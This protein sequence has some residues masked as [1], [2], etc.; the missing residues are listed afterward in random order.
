MKRIGII[1]G[2][3]WKSTLH[4]YEQL[5]QRVNEEAGGLTSADMVLRSVNF[6]EFY[7]LMK[8]GKWDVIEQK[9]YDEVRHL[10][11]YEKC[12]YV[13]IATNTMHI[14]VPEI[15]RQCFFR[16]RYDPIVHIGACIAHE[17]R[18]IN[19]K[20]VLLL[21]TEFTMTVNFMNKYLYDE[22]GIKS[23]SLRDKRDKIKEINRIVFDE[24]CRGVVSPDSKQFLIDFVNQ[25][26]RSDDSDAA[27]VAHGSVA[28]VLGCTELGM[29][30]KQEDFDIP[31]IDSTEAHIGQLVKLSLS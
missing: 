31:V 10:L 5:N 15:S 11:V 22:H 1:G 3:S 8:E 28:V 13:A 9:L 23:F 7:Q 6:D 20:K 24:L 26:I 29:I 27:S 17:C 4:Y 2:M 19:V 12:A 25:T 14:V 16:L 30:L 21:G 18:K